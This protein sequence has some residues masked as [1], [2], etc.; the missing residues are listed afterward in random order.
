MKT[1]R[2]FV[3]FLALLLVPDGVGLVG[4][5]SAADKTEPLTLKVSMSGPPTAAR[6]KVY[7]EFLWP[8]L[9]KRT[10][11][12]VR[13]ELY[14]AES[15]IKLKEGLV[16][17]GKGIADIA[18]FVPAYTDQRTP[19]GHTVW[20][21]YQCGDNVL[22]GYMAVAELV[23]RFPEVFLLGF[24]E[25]GV[26]P[27]FP[28]FAGRFVIA[29]NKP[30][31]KKEDLKGIKL[32][33]VG[34]TGEWLASMGATISSVPYTEVYTALERGTIDGGQFYFQDICSY[35]I[36]EVAKYVTDPGSGYLCTSW[37]IINKRVW[38]RLPQDVRN[39]FLDIR[40]ELFERL[41]EADNRESQACKEEIEKRGGEFIYLTRDEQERWK[42]AARFLYQRLEDKIDQR[43]ELQEYLRTRG[44]SGQKIVKE[45]EDTVVKYRSRLAK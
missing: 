33:G 10:G 3:L 38:E 35:R 20:L 29:T 7:S 40:R 15:L 1:K 5:V 4:A 18:P 36:S 11:K 32:R 43:R 26:V 23:E 8:E 24:E 31:R 41:A 25:S 19:F 17:V 34:E 21:P 13:F 2:L 37:Y 14:Y 45:V 44:L 27:F 22:A 39:A 9:E 6:E 12:K 30:V 16:G 28:T 42:E